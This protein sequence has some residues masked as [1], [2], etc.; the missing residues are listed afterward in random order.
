MRSLFQTQVVS[1]CRPC[2]GHIGRDHMQR[3]ADQLVRKSRGIYRASAAGV[4]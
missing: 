4:V 3:T 1:L 2:C